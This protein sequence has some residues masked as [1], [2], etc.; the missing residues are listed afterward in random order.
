MRTELFIVRNVGLSLQLFFQLSFISYV[1]VPNIVKK[2]FKIIISECIP[3]SL[4]HVT[5]ADVCMHDCIYGNIHCQLLNI[6]PTSFVA[7]TWLDYRQYFN[8]L[9]LGLNPLN[10]LI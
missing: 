3:K 1:S 2:T 7:E 6:L 8:G 10:A 5:N 9:I 4:I